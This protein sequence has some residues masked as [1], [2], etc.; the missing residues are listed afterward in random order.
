MSNRARKV[1]QQSLY[2]GPRMLDIGSGV[3]AM[4]KDNQ[5]A[6]QLDF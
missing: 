4:I 6:K 5:R 1:L 3:I 2:T